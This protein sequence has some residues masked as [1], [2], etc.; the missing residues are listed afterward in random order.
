[1][2]RFKLEIALVA[3]LA[4]TLVGVVIA[5]PG[6][7]E[8]PLG[9]GSLASPCAGTPRIEGIADVGREGDLA[10]VIALVEDLRS[11]EFRTDPD[12][13]Y[14]A[15]AAFG[16]RVASMPVF[17]EGEAELLQNVLVNLRAIPHEYD[18]ERELTET[19]T[20]GVIGFYE[21]ETEELVVKGTGGADGFTGL[22]RMTLV[23]EL[24]HALA[25][26]VHGFRPL[27]DPD[28]DE[29]A[30]AAYRALVEGDAE[31]VTETYAA[32]A[33]GF[34]DAIEIGLVAGAAGASAL[35]A[36]HF[37][38]RSL[39]F[40]YLEGTAFACALYERGGW[41]AVD[42]AYAD[43][44]DTT[45]EILFPET[46]PAPPPRDLRDPIGPG[47]PWEPAATMTFG[48]AD[49]LFLLETVEEE[50]ATTTGLSP[51]F[52]PI[53]IAERWRAGEVHLW[54]TGTRSAV[55]L[56]I[57]GPRGDD[58]LCHAIA[59]WYDAGH[60]L[61]RKVAYADHLAFET[62]GRTGVLRCLRDGGLVRL[63]IGPDLSVA[64]AAAT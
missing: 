47:D 41:A 37:I 24:E 13:V 48:A 49:L 54:T 34:A 32:Q 5:G 11:L 51:D 8:E 20:D 39:T 36:P 9:G 29:D 38:V 27:D 61:A 33:L 55:A 18:L 58:R 30:L 56:A 59:D 6:G 46:Y 31:L 7:R 26:Q 4:A 23:H 19:T 10:S 44:P 60:P 57:A 45:H 15:P 40:P 42:A 62:D 64:R 16:E 50:P 63:G 14:L 12:P 35:D 43:P 1:M 25:D 17:R 3:L 28:A 53:R 22:E 52:P 2:G 21:P